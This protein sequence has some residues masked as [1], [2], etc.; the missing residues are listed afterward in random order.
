MD[1]VCIS[2]DKNLHERVVEYQLSLIQ[3]RKKSVSFSHAA[4]LLFEKG[5]GRA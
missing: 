5:L 1:K 3:R 2:I 4:S